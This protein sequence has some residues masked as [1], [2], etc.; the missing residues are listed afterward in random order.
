MKLKLY[1]LSV[2]SVH[3][4]TGQKKIYPVLSMSIGLWMETFLPMMIRLKRLVVIALYE[5]IAYFQI[6]D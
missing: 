4:E 1:P 3:A 2:L 5:E 6:F